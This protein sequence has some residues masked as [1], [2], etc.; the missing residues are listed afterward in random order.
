[1]LVRARALISAGHPGPSVAITALVAL[2]AA[3]SGS[4]G[5]DFA[6]AV[7]AM[8]AGQLS[9]GWSNDAADARRDAAAGRRDK[10]VVTG[11]VSVRAV[12]VAAV[13]ALVTALSLGLALG[14]PTALLLAVV[15][16][17][18]WVYNLGAKATTASGLMYILGFGPLPAYAASA[19]PGQPLPQW[20][21]TAAA[22]LVG[23]GGHFANV[24]PDLA[25]D[26][27]T[28]VAGLP[29]RV[30]ARW[31]PG[32]VRA[33]ALI[34]LLSASVLLLF[35][36]GGHPVAWVG[37]GVA[38]LLAVIAALGTGR[39]PFAA[40]FGIA[41]VDVVLLVVVGYAQA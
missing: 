22:A 14:V 31:G 9:I 24:L 30:G 20:Y 15:V 32:A 27:A 39:V 34:L 26:R 36:S 8:L 23:L 4:R 40:A 38:A 12:W 3:L 11:A 7:T 1:M 6:L 29:Q 28:G 25:A 21:A 13:A 19:L 2:L 35:A 5:G 37:L 17:A 16:G 10:P 41:A 33:S 18:G